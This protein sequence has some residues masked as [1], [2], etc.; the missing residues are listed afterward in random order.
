M[1]S[2]GAPV[3]APRCASCGTPHAPDQKFC[4]ECGTRRWGRPRRRVGA[5]ARAVRG[6]RGAERR[7]SCVWCRC[8]SSISSATHRSR[9]VVTPRKC[10]SCSVATSSPRARS[11]G[12]TPARVEK[13]IGDAVM[14]VW[15][16]PIAREDDAE[17]AVR[18]GLEILD[19]VTRLRGRSGRAGPACAGGVVTGQVAALA[20][21]GEGL[22][23]G[24]RVNTASRAQSAAE[25]GTAGGRRRD[26]RSHLCGDRLRGRRR[27]RRQRQVRADSP[28]AGHACDRRPRRSRA[29][30]RDRGPADRP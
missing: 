20:N 13:F 28:V 1:R 25:P 10:A 22:V 24:D 4:A 3:Q 8:C 18:A 30:A 9:R 27:S 21:P 11:S 2:A 5:R 19:A 14:A 29:R 26:P 12:A 17:R 23:V 15:G 6:A 7:P 16:V